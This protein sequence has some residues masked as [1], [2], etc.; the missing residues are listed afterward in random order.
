MKF[1]AVNGIEDEH[2]IWMVSIDGIG[3][4][5]KKPNQKTQT[6]KNTQFGFFL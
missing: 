3:C 4:F 1:K 5:L 6:K 2:V